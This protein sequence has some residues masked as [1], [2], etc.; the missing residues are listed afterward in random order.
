MYVVGPGIATKNVIRSS[1]RELI[2]I[3]PASKK[4]KD[5]VTGQVHA[6]Q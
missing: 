4:V 3:I 5:F 2:L 1:D 6:H